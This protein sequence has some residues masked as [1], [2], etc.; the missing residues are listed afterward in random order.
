MIVLEV[1][2]DEECQRECPDVMW[3]FWK[4]KLEDRYA[5][6]CQALLMLL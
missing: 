4:T 6:S 3:R 1:A 5:A 2:P